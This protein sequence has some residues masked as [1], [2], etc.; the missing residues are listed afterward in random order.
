M[1]PSKCLLAVEASLA[2]EGKSSEEGLLV[3]TT[4]DDMMTAMVKTLV[5][6][7]ET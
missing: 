5:D 2:I 4:G 6:C 3:L 1:K 7:L